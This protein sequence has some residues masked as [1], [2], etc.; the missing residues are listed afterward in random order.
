[1]D[2][3][4][5]RWL[6]AGPLAFAGAV[7]FFYVSLPWPVL[8]P[9]RNP[10]E[11]AFMELRIAQSRE[12]D[13]PLRIQQS[14]RPLGEISRNLRRAVLVAEDARFY[15]HGGIDWQALSQEV[16]YKGDSDFSWFDVG[17]LR[18]LFGSLNYYRAHRDRVRGRSTLTQQLAKNLYFTED[19][20]LSR[21]VGEFV[22]ARRLELFMSKDRI[23]EVYLNVVEWGPG[24]F[25]AEAAARHYFG[26]SA[27]NLTAEQAAALAATLPHPL[28]S[29]PKRRPGRMAWRKSLILARMGVKGPVQ[30]VPLDSTIPSTDS[31]TVAPPVDSTAPPVDT[32]KPPAQPDSLR[33]DTLSIPDTIVT[34]R[35]IAISRAS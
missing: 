8:L 13:K 29:N 24:I 12:Q 14:W 25:G 23:L 10:R 35:S 11:T 34:A 19:R 17:D 30:T 31:A 5:K 2:F 26:R 33:R 21:K 27:R 15:E 20:S 4:W 3:T 32:S 7:W 28:T 9:F 22:V 16:R 1:M 6:Y 18:A